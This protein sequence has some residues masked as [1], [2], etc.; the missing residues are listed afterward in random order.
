MRGARYHAEAI[1]RGL[2]RSRKR[3][4]RLTRRLL[5]DG[6]S[7]YLVPMTPEEKGEYIRSQMRR[8]NEMAPEEQLELVRQA[9]EFAGELG[10]G[11]AFLGHRPNVQAT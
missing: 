10:V 11:P 7:P 9:E 3:I 1:R 2:K 5:V 6:Y 4:D 8:M